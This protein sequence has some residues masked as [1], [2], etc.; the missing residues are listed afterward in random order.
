MDEPYEIDYTPIKVP[1]AEIPEAIVNR[2]KREK[3]A[4]LSASHRT[5]PGVLSLMTNV[6]RVTWDS[7]RF[8]CANTVDHPSRRLDFIVA[9]PPLSRTILDAISLAASGVM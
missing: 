5:L 4:E 7:V 1:L 8:L 9:V 2:I 6:V 3:D